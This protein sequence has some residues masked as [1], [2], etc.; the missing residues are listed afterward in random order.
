MYLQVKYFSATHQEKDK[1][2]E[3]KGSLHLKIKHIFK[4]SM[5]CPQLYRG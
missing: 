3:R 2:L 1:S 5:V 4:K